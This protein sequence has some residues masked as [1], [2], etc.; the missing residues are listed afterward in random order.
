MPQQA[1]SAPASETGRK[2]VGGDETTGSTSQVDA[3]EKQHNS[4]CIK[5]ALPAEVF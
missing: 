1:V 3:V 2:F 5:H 4:E